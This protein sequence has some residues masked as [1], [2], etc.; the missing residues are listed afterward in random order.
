MTIPRRR[1][2]SKERMGADDKKEDN[3]VFC[4]YF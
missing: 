2:C 3:D 1:W 4:Y